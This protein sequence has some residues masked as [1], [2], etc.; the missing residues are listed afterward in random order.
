MDRSEN[1]RR[2]RSRDTKPELEVRRLVFSMG[3]RYRLHGADIPGKPD[4]VFRKHRK[5]IFVHGCFWHQHGACKAGRKPKSNEGYWTRKLN[6]NVARDKATLRQLRKLGWDTLVVW[7][8]QAKD[9]QRLS[10]RILKFLN[11]KGRRLAHS[12]GK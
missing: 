5:A 8:C 1:M 9:A 7:E 6:R 12:G 4:M 10:T 11:F 2:I 3:F